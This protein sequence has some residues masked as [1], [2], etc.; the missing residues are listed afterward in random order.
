MPGRDADDPDRDLANVNRFTDLARV[1]GGPGACPDG[2]GVPDGCYNLRC[3]PPP[4]IRRSTVQPA[5]PISGGPDVHAIDDRPTKPWWG[6]RHRAQ[7]QTVVL[8]THRTSVD[9]RLVTLPDRHL[10]LFQPENIEAGLRASTDPQRPVLSRTISIPEFAIHDPRPGHT[11]LATDRYLDPKAS[12]QR[13][14]DMCSETGP[15]PSENPRRCAGRWGPSDPGADPTSCQASTPDGC[16]RYEGECYDQTLIHAN[17]VDGVW[18]L[19]GSP[20]TIFVPD[21]KTVESATDLYGTS[22]E[23]PLE[24]LWIY[25]RNVVTDPVELPQYDDYWY[26]LQVAQV[27]PGVL[28]WE[29]PQF[30]QRVQDQCMGT[31][32]APW[33]AWLDNQ[34]VVAGS[35][36]F[37]HG[38]GAQDDE[39]WDGHGGHGLLEPATTADGRLLML[40]DKGILYAYNDGQQYGP[41]DVRGWSRFEPLSMAH[42]DPRLRERYGLARY[43]IHDTQG[44]AY[45]PGEEIG[46][47]YPWIDRRGNN[48]M[49]PAATSIHDGFLPTWRSTGALATQAELNQTNGSGVVVVGS[50]TRGRMINLDNG[51]NRTDFSFG[52]NAVRAEIFDLPLYDTETKAVRP[53]GISLLSSLESSFAHYDAFAPPL[54][55]DVVWH[56]SSSEQYNALVVFD[57]YLDPDALVVAHGNA[58]LRRDVS[59]NVNRYRGSPPD[60]QVGI[61][62]DD[63]FEPTTDD[64]WLWAFARSPRLQNAATAPGPARLQLRGGAWIPPVAEGGVLGKGVFLDGLNDHITVDGLPI[65][66]RGLYVG[67]WIDSRDP[68]WATGDG[69]PR[70]VLT[71]RDGSVVGLTKTQAVIMDVAGVEHAIDLSAVGLRA[72]RWF[73]FAAHVQVNP[74]GRT[75]SL[76]LLVNGNPVGTATTIDG[77]R[78]VP[79]ASVDAPGCAYR[80][81]GLYCS[82]DGSAAVVCAWGNQVYALDC[83]ETF[84]VCDPSLAS[85][86]TNPC[87][88]PGPEGPWSDASGFVV[89]I[90]REGPWPPLRGWVDEVRAYRVRPGLL[91]GRALREH[92]C[93]LALGSLRNDGQ[94]DVCDIVDLAHDEALEA[95]VGTGLDLAPQA[96]LHRTCGSTVHADADPACVRTQALGTAD[97]YLVAHEPRPDQSDVGFCIRCHQDPQDPVPGLRPAALVPGAASVLAFEDPRRQPMAWPRWMPGTEPRLHGDAVPPT[98][99]GW[100]GDESIDTLILGGDRFTPPSRIR[101]R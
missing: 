94:G 78:T 66:V 18:E 48:L 70:A 23:K 22:G 8:P 26:D 20:V 53:G 62:P 47:G 55:F 72:E 80:D 49:F 87:T 73:H 42:Q 35:Y 61:Y 16:P 86:G 39:V 7:P 1:A 56:A 71:F 40:H 12:H 38:P 59:V 37:G 76:Q 11:R 69:Q 31:N 89:G 91:Q 67:L 97:K 9:G 28:D 29:R 96:Y 14:W 51:L 83:W 77:L 93:N 19:R 30:V 25:P 2:F 81:D 32:P 95:E 74:I 43:P 5:V 92:Q 24:G 60:L 3:P 15:E 46:G 68:D 50:W 58:P 10:A 17:A 41:C 99:D 27:T 65:D 54:P 57:E 101:P 90:D 52:A 79:E 84:S 75:A 85:S 100:V 64:G 4:A 34:Q 82:P 33:C 44:V 13:F 88:T 6:Q 21:G 36:V 63:G 45:A 98:A